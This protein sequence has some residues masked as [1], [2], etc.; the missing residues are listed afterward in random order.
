MT[1]QQW[2][3]NGNWHSNSPPTLAIDDGGLL[4]GVL[5]TDRIRTS[6]H[7]L[8]RLDDHLFRFRQSCE[9]CNVQ[10]LASHDELKTIV[11][12]LVELNAKLIADA[13]DLN[14]IL[15]ATPGHANTPTLIGYTEPI[16]FPRYRSMFTEGAGL[17]IPPT[18]QLPADCIDP[19]AKHRSRLHW[20]IAQ[21]QA[22][23]I[24]PKADAL[25]LGVDG[26]VRETASANIVVVKNGELL[27]PQTGTVLPGVSLKFVQELCDELDL[28]FRE[29]KLRPEDCY[30]A[31]EII[32]TC[33]SWCLAGVSRIDARSIPWPGPIY[34]RLLA[35]WC[36]IMG[37]DIVGQI[38]SDASSKRR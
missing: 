13:E 22:H 2:Y 8:F 24:D 38:L 6:R 5:V 36:E 18:K 27:T 31:D 35:K 4:Y 19:R 28:P 15:L 14:V 7:Q 23:E 29:Q 10:L 16:D 25:L 11:L 30:I 17:V 1:A 9:I 3:C 32:L 20:W 21:N 12:R 33:T 26:F 34:Q 37:I